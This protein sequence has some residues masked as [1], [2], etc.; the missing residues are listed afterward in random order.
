MFGALGR[1]GSTVCWV[2][3]DIQA[4]RTFSFCRVELTERC[5]E[6]QA[7]CLDE[8]RENKGLASPACFPGRTQH[9]TPSARISQSTLYTS[10]LAGRGIRVPLLKCGS[11]RT[12]WG[13]RFF[14]STL[15]VLEIELRSSGLVAS[16][17]LWYRYEWL[18]CLNMWHACTVPSGAKAWGPL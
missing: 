11:Q 1:E 12:I 17:T 4:T 16:A 10:V 14:L 8:C 9:S 2:E 5:V 15:W 18:S 7:G 6:S 3:G 13:S